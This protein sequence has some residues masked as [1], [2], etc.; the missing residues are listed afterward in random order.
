MERF[1][2]R[3]SAR[4]G[5]NGNMK[6]PGMV[7][8]LIFA[9]LLLIGCALGGMR[10]TPAGKYKAG[11]IA[12]E[13]GPSESFSVTQ[14]ASAQD[15]RSFVVRGTYTYTLEHKDTYNE[16]TYGHLDVI[17]SSITLNGATAGG[18]DVT[19]LYDGND[20]AP[21]DTLLGWWEFMVNAASGPEMLVRLNVPA[22]GGRPADPFSGSNWLI[23][24]YPY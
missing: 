19:S 23:N 15:S 8:A 14:T 7:L 20:F 3:I 6:K 13:L 21:G 12:F 18:L 22:S 1:H 9:L 5:E 16:I 24:G 17:V 2:D 10:D 11:S 4:L